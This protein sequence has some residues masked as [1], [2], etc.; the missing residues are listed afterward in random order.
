MTHG[1]TAILVTLFVILWCLIGTVLLNHLPLLSD[2]RLRLG[3]HRGAIPL[4]S[5]LVTAILIAF[6][7]V[8][9]A[10]CAWLMRK[11]H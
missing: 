8:G 10:L 9:K 5:L 6:W 3:V 4:R 11:L 1:I 2:P 7:P